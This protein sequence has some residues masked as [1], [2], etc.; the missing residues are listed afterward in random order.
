MLDINTLETLLVVGEHDAGRHRG[1]INAV[2]LSKD[3]VCVHILSGV[4]P[5]EADQAGYPLQGIGQSKSGAYTLVTSSPL[6]N[7]LIQEVSLLSI[8]HRHH[9]QPSRLMDEW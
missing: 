3:Y 8:S 9:P 4:Y 6:S 2:N 5:L 1:A 7:Q